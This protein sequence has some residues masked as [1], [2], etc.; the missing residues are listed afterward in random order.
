MTRA[1]RVLVVLAGYVL[2]LVASAGVVA[3][4]DIRF[5]AYDN[6]TMGGMIAGGE[7]MLGAGVF[8]VASLLPTG[9]ALW[10]LRRSRAFWSAFTFAGIAFAVLGLASAFSVLGMR[11]SAGRMGF[12]DFVG[13]FGLIHML[14]SPIWIGGFVVFAFLAPWRDL[15]RRMLMAVAAELLVAGCGVL[16]FMSTRPL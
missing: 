9:L 10:Y 11:G 3:L 14:G 5:T 7:M 16:Q 13:L 12:M 1:K 6:Q 8:F 4:Y 2:A 15:R